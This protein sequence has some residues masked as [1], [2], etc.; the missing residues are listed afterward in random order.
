[1]LGLD[2]NQNMSFAEDSTTA[3]KPTAVNLA[4][5]PERI[6]IQ[7]SVTVP[8]KFQHIQAQEGEKEER[9]PAQ[10]IEILYTH[11]TAK[12]VSFSTSTR[13]AVTYEPGTLSW[14]SASER[15][16]AVGPLE[17]YRVPGSVSFLHSGSLL[18][19]ILPRS[20]CWC[21]DGKSTF[22]F[23]A[24]PNQYY[25]IELSSDTH[26]DM[27]QVEALISTFKKILYY[28]RTPCPFNREIAVDSTVT[29]PIE[30]KKARRKS[31][32]EPAKK[33]KLD[34]IWRPE[35]ESTPIIQAAS[36][37]EKHSPAVNKLV[38]S[39]TRKSSNQD[40]HSSIMTSE[41]EPPEIRPPSNIYGS[42][43]VTVPP[44]LTLIASPPSKTSSPISNEDNVVGL[45]L[46]A[47]PPVVGNGIT[48]N[49]SSCETENE[50]LDDDDSGA[51]GSEKLRISLEE[52]Q[53]AVLVNATIPTPTTPQKPKL[54]M[55][56]EPR[57]LVTKEPSTPSLS[58][59]SED[60]S[61]EETI[62]PP[63]ALR[64]RKTRRQEPASP[65]RSLPSSYTETQRLLPQASKTQNFTNSDGLVRKVLIGPSSN[66]ISTMLKMASRLSRG[67]DFTIK[68]P[69]GSPQRVPGEWRVVEDCEDDWN[70]DDYGFPV[71]IP[72]I[73]R[74]MRLNS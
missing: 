67:F 11:S 17:I 7:R 16:L 33:W 4:K 58:S 56:T 36:P 51:K 3:S 66:L 63:P 9:G 53:S 25:R 52:A 8:A 62:T 18:H 64:L 15:T 42:R 46:I 73:R 59:D 71:S 38:E 41:T 6:R 26:E 37:P 65:I 49:D 19:A 68:S 2:A 5:T 31:A 32:A 13:I 43:G 45:G 50:K 14:R 29:Q 24:L 47:S 30:E 12:I 70:I 61:W 69:P 1:M 40:Q 23:R 35:G 55:P 54:N 34:G 60:H 28:E 39:P 10:G 72:G 74:D 22:V 44:Q 57:P 20:Q 27:E 48:S 21:V